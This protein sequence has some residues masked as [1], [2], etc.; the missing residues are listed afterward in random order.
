MVGFLYNKLVLK[1]NRI[2]HGS[3]FRAAG[4]FAADLCDKF[5]RTSIE[6]DGQ[7]QNAGDQPGFGQSN[8]ANTVQPIDDNDDHLLPM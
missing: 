7:I 2:P 1:N 6:Q 4:N 3:S 5:F 8:Q